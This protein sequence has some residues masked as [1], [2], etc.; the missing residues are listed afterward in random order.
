MLE[1]LVDFTGGPAISFCFS[2]L[3]CIEPFVNPWPMLTN[4]SCLFGFC[5]LLFCPSGLTGWKHRPGTFL[6]VVSLFL[7]VRSDTP[8][9]FNF[10]TTFQIF[11]ISSCFLLFCW[12]VQDIH[13]FQGF[14]RVHHLLE[15]GQTFGIGKTMVGS[16]I[17]GFWG[18]W[19]WGRFK[20]MPGL[21]GRGWWIVSVPSPTWWQLLPE[22]KHRCWW[23]R[24]R[25]LRLD[26]F[27]MGC[28][29]P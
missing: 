27:G 11:Q 22:L 9:C 15:I 14:R 10:W 18:P 24:S 7:R 28:V 6:F 21:A 8:F 12:Q 25:W 17:Y 23:E 19:N 26:F 13:S 4:F 16:W 1:K 3:L 2:V 29:K 5:S 20:K